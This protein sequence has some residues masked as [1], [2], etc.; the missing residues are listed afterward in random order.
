MGILNGRDQLTSKFIT[1]EITDSSNRVHYV[2]I[3]H[4]IGEY[5]VVD[6]DG[7][8]YAF[9]MKDARILTHRKTATKS[10]QVIQYDTSHYSSIKPET[11]ELEIALKK[12][13]LP[14]MDRMLH[15]VLRVLGRREKD[16]KDEFEPHRIDELIEMF[17]E[18]EG[19]FPE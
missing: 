4:T 10:F 19:E 17:S 5:F 15:D 14:R 18:K 3:K 13:S 6:L 16:N 1:A 8:F 11:K 2:P 9:T 12:N 7:H